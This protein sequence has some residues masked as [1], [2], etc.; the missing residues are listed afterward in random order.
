MTDLEYN[1]EALAN[2]IRWMITNTNGIEWGEDIP[3]I[4]ADI[5]GENGAELAKIAKKEII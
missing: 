4:V 2:S 3:Y 1:A 5:L